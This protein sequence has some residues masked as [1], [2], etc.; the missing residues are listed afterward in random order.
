MSEIQEYT[1]LW[2]CCMFC[3]P[4]HSGAD[5]SPR[6][7]AGHVPGCKGK[8][9][10]NPDFLG[11]LG[12]KLSFW[13]L[14]LLRMRSTTW[15]SLKTPTRSPSR[16]WWTVARATQSPASWSTST[17]SGPTRTERCWLPA[18]TTAAAARQIWTTTEDYVAEETLLVPTFRS[19]AESTEH[20]LFPR[21]WRN[22]WIDGR[23]RHSAFCSWLLCSC[24]EDGIHVFLSLTF[25]K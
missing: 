16:T 15:W 17:A 1:H 20:F 7:G 25:F 4:G 14:P 13:S 18:T 11:F 21:A 10:T 5:E 23:R 12:E 9:H 2:C 3:S 6:T 19:Q 24:M 22:E 8:V